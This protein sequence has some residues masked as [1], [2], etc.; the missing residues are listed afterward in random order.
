MSTQSAILGMF[1]CTV[2]SFVLALAFFHVYLLPV[3]LEKSDN[4]VKIMS[5]DVVQ[6]RLVGAINVIDECKENGTVVLP[7]HSGV[8]GLVID[9]QEIKI[10]AIAQY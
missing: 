10:K 5:Q 8:P 1:T 3:E 7:G 2:S 6:S 4:L 9:C